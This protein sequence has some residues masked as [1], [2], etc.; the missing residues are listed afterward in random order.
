MNSVVIIGAGTVGL[1]TGATLAAHGYPVLFV[2]SSPAR[3]AELSAGGWDTSAAPRLAAPHTTAFVCTPT[4]VDESGYDLSSVEPA[5]R[6]LVRMARSTAA[7]IDV[8][9][10][11]TV[12]PGTCD[13]P[14]TAWIRDEAPNR[15]KTDF[16]V[17]H[18]PEFLREAHAFDDARSPRSIVIGAT[19]PSARKRLERLMS[20]SSAPV[21]TFDTATAAELVK[22]AHNAYNATKIS[23]WNEIE[24]MARHLG[25]D[26]HAV[27]KV[28]SVTAE[29]SWN[30][31]YGIR[32]GSPYGGA[33]LPKDVLGLISPF[34]DLGLAP[35]VL[36]AVHERNR[37]TS[38][39]AP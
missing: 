29:A 35:N 13:G 26:G 14:V 19:D 39:T 21:E 28:V 10:R 24:I 15:S 25:V 4:P 30:P 34:R 23:F 32:G 9:I 8:V 11:S 17:V 3:R 5:V 20:G 2:D 6:S 37:R 12:A 22:C 36:T 33:C 7:T 27:A 1:A 18:C 38:E 16:P 31:D